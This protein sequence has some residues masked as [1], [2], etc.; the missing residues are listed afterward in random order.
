MR[1]NTDKIEISIK[2]FIDFKY[3][4]IF[5]VKCDSPGRERDEK[6]VEDEINTLPLCLK[7]DN[8]KVRYKF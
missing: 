2:G 3:N 5:A 1:Q 6:S 8:S 7:A 4:D